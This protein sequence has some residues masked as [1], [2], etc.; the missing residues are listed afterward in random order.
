MTNWK[1]YL[2]RVAR[3]RDHA[4]DLSREEAEA[5]F[6]AWLDG[7][8]PEHVAGAFWVAYRSKYPPAKPEALVRE[9]LKAA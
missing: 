2:S 3:G 4:E 8:L 5:L 9:P 6:I 7:A 1:S